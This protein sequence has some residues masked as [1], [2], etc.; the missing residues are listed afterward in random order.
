[1]IRI[2]VSNSRCRDGLVLVSC[3]PRPA[4]FQCLKLWVLDS[5]EWCSRPRQR[6]AFTRPVQKFKT[7]PKTSLVHPTAICRRSARKKG[8]ATIGA[9]SCPFQALGMALRQASG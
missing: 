3:R 2:R 7:R 1:M 8:G 9:F 5:I 4:I 6:A